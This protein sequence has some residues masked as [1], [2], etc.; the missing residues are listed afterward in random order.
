MKGGGGKYSTQRYYSNNKK[1]WGKKD[2]MGKR[3]KKQRKREI[4]MSIYRTLFR[5]PV[6][7]QVSCCDLGGFDRS[8]FAMATVSWQPFGTPPHPS[9]LPQPS[10]AASLPIWLDAQLKCHASAAHVH[11]RQINQAEAVWWKKWARRTNKRNKEKVTRWEGEKRFLVELYITVLSDSKRKLCQ[12]VCVFMWLTLVRR[13]GS[14]QARST[15]A[16]NLVSAAMYRI[17]WILTVNYLRDVSC[18]GYLR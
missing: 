13:T 18:E 14:F 2:K 11:T 12:Q 3:T 15:K 9:S 1:K 16:E 10:L 8:G 6:A 5:S 4:L 17:K 7:L